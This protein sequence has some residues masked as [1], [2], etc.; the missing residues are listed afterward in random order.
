LLR[1]VLS[2][3]GYDVETV[4]TLSDAVQFAVSSLPNLYLLEVHLP[5][6]IG[7]DLIEQIKTLTP[8]APIIIC[9]ADVRDATRQRAKSIGVQAFVAKPVNLDMLL[10]TVAQLLPIR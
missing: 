3:A 9:S 2:D 6:G 8:A 1:F 5:D 4:Q 7:F 10:A